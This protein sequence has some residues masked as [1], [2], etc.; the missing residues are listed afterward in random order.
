MINQRTWVDSTL[1]HAN[2]AARL[3]NVLIAIVAPFLVPLPIALL[4]AYDMFHY[5]LPVAMP[6]SMRLLASGIGAISIE[7][8]SIVTFSFIEKA[9]L[10]QINRQ[11]GQPGRQPASSGAICQ[12]WQLDYYFPPHL[13]AEIIPLGG[14]AAVLARGGD[15]P[16]H[17]GLILPVKQFPGLQQTRRHGTPGR[18]AAE[19]GLHV[20]QD[21]RP[22]VDQLGTPGGGQI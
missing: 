2:E 12:T 4:V 13:L 14:R 16:P 6:V 3:L 17:Q 8:F 7:F 1:H 11:D 15:H 18:Q 20:G 21:A 10:Y 9:K 22:V 19:V 5:V